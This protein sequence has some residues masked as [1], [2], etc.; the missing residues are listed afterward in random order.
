MR[1][2]MTPLNELVSSAAGEMDMNG[3]LICHRVNVASGRGT[4][5]N[6]LQF[7]SSVWWC[8]KSKSGVNVRLSLSGRLSA[9][10]SPRVALLETF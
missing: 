9:E 8:S 2:L 6:T 7:S 1:Q 10:L 3:R 5:S 4:V